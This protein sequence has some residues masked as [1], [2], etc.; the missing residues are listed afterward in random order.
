MSARVLVVGYDAAEATLLEAWAEA[1]RLP[2]LTALTRAGTTV[3]LANSLETLPGAIWPELTTGIS[4]G[5]R[6]LF[7]HPRQVHTGEAV[8]RPVD[9][10]EVDAEEQ[11]WVRAARQGRRIAVLDLPQTVPAPGVD[12]IQ[13]FEWGLH[14]RN[15]AIT[16]EPPELLA[17][18]RRRFGDHPVDVCDLAHGRTVAGYE[19]LLDDLLAGISTKRTFATELLDREPWD[20]F[21]IGVGE[22]HCVGHQF[23]HFADP[24][25]PRHDPVTPRRLQ[26]AMGAVYEAMDATLGALV[27]RAG[28]DATIVLVASHGMGP[29][30][31]GYQ[32]LPI[33]LERMGLAPRPNRAAQAPS[34]LPEP[35]RDVLRRVVPAR[36]RHRR[37]VA[38]GRLH[39]RTWLESPTCQAA[40]VENNRCGAIR[41]NL[42]GR[43]PHGCVV[44]GAEADALVE[45]LRRELLDLRVPETDE[46]IVVRVV[47]ADEAFGPDHHPDVPDVLVVFRDDLGRLE[48]C[49]S[50]SLGSIEKPIDNPRLP[51]TGDH[52]VESRL[53]A[54]GPGIPA[55]AVRSDGNVLDLAP[56]VLTLLGCEIPPGLD[57]HP[58]RFGAP[59]G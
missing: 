7:F 29:Y 43:E 45:R 11:F 42:V 26:D 40:P 8:V 28:P 47:T 27:E 23:R 48:R 56:T 35:V 16:S 49:W 39:T 10:D 33:L 13:L 12:G 5:R 17:D 55:G 37:L 19:R 22:S 2:A 53:W 38:T 25:D 18:L 51:R 34:R 24:S 6:A 41:L 30:I 36:A 52:T 14:D 15:F 9:A 58:I 57:G 20:L 50:P 4:C 3:R 54:C 21:A 59:G 31:G 46:R 1:G 32:L 44:P